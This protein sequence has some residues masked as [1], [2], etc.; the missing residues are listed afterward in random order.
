M[1][2]QEDDKLM[3]QKEDTRIKKIKK[4]PLYVK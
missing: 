3:E 4:D 2:A 1:K